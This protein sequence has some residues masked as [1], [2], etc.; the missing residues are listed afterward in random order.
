MS[1]T[2]PENVIESWIG[3]DAPSDTDLIQVWIDRSERLLRSRIPGLEARVDDSGGDEP[4]LLEMVQDVV[5]AMVTR[6]FRNPEGRRQTSSTTGP[7]SEQVTFGGDEP[8]SMWLTDDEYDMLA[9][10]TTGRY[11]AFQIDPLIGYTLPTPA[12]SWSET[13]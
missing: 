3:D 4:D 5:V 7:F 9:G 11:H 8:G 1:W 6:V 2:D 13:A 12:D 10:S